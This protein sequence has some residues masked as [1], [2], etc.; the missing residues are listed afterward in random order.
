MNKIINEKSLK[1][2]INNIVDNIIIKNKINLDE[3]E[4]L[5]LKNIALIHVLNQDFFR[6]SGAR[7]FLNMDMNNLLYAS[8][9][10]Q[11]SLNINI[12]NIDKMPYILRKNYEKTY[13]AYSKQILQDSSIDMLKNYVDTVRNSKSLMDLKINSPELLKVFLNSN[14]ESGTKFLEIIEF[15]SK[16]LQMPYYISNSYNSDFMAII[17]KMDKGIPVTEILDYYK[18]NQLLR[19]ENLDHLCVNIDF[20]IEKVIN[21]FKTNKVLQKTFVGILV[22]DKTINEKIMDLIDKQSFQEIKSSIIKYWDN[23]HSQSFSDISKPYS[24]I[25]DSVLTEFKNINPILTSSKNYQETII[26]SKDA[27]ELDLENKQEFVQN[28][29]KLINNK[30]VEFPYDGL[31]DGKSYIIDKLSLHHLD[32]FPLEGKDNGNDDE[33]K[34]IKI[35]IYHNEQEC[36]GIIKTEETK[37]KS[38]TKVIYVSAHSFNFEYFTD[39][40]IKSLYN[41]FL[42]SHKNKIVI[43]TDS[44]GE[45]SN[46]INKI[47]NK[48]KSE[49]KNNTVIFTQDQFHSSIDET[50]IETYVNGKIKSFILSSPLSLA[51]NIKI[52]NKLKETLNH[53][54]MNKLV[55]HYEEIDGQPL[56]YYTKDNFDDMLSPFIDKKI[57][58]IQSKLFDKSKKLIP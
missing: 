10:L 12:P 38:N 29:Y 11:D 55:R 28:V 34:D 17:S 30:L 16:D 1:N 23:V 40:E 54:E 33:Y 35:H 24:K 26:D 27:L 15:M 3:K 49:N 18:I 14:I 58:Q 56:I 31:S 9:R 19:Q 43:F 48:F 22:S 46:Y 5:D 32:I 13:D 47:V 53:D 44:Y 25:L 52:I 50:Y 57:T 6:S 51:D 41:N 7:S 39:K 36:N 8:I 45:N 20:N 2:T 21:K 37:T 4:K 42:E